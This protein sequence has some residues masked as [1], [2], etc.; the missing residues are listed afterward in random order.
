M[1]EQSWLYHENAGIL[2]ELLLEDEGL[3]LD[4]MELLEP[5]T[6]SGPSIGTATILMALL[7]VGEHLTHECSASM[8]VGV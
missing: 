1:T 6:T 4:V 5:L 8:G 2:K 3:T 7:K